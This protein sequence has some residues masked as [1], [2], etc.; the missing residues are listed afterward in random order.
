M[1]NVQ[2]AID[3]NHIRQPSGLDLMKIIFADDEYHFNFE[4]NMLTLVYIN[5]QAM[6]K[7]NFFICRNDTIAELQYS[8]SHHF[9][10]LEINFFSN[11]ENPLLMSSCVMFSPEVR[12]QD[13]SP[14]CQ[15]GCIELNDKMTIDEL[16]HSIY[17]HFKL[18]VEI[19]P[20]T[21]HR[22]FHSHQPVGWLLKKENPEGVRLP[23]RSD[24]VHHNYP[25][26]GH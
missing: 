8:F 24:I 5:T 21:G 3:F 20:G 1:S 11:V 12:I 23:E 25:S 10:S 14:G 18:H 13:I 2:S 4:R 16:E 19:S 6:N 26:F 7:T 17:D 22:S 15:D 9:P